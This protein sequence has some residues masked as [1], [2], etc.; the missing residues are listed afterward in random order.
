MKIF[1]KT[2]DKLKKPEPSEQECKYDKGW[3]DAIKKVEE[4]IFSYS[5]ADMWIPTDVKLPPEPD[6]RESPEDKIKYNVTIKDAEL[7][8]TLTYLGGGRWGMV[9][10]HGI[11]YYPVIA[12]QPMPPV[13][14]PG[15]VTPLEITIGIGTDEIKEIIMEH[16]KTKGFNVTED[17][18]SFV[19]GKEETVTGNTKKIK[20]ALI[21]CDIQIER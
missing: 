3:N 17:D 2:L 1:L 5:P 4:L 12:W 7:P 6:V 21:R 13:Y 8:T 9:E 10:E 18:I 16:I 20:H 15:E 14:K 11:A 19:I